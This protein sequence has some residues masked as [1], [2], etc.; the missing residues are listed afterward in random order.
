MTNATTKHSYWL[1]SAR[2][3]FGRDDWVVPMRF[4]RHPDSEF[5][6]DG[7]SIYTKVMHVG[8]DLLT[9]SLGAA[10]SLYFVSHAQLTTRALFRGWLG[11]CARR[12]ASAWTSLGRI[13]SRTLSTS[14]LSS[15]ES[16]FTPCRSSLAS[17]QIALTL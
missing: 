8:S 4:N 11:P 16:F 3:G 15:S 13:G 6:D 7:T 2:I 5:Q 14:P 17:P 1:A 10:N 12:L 9:R